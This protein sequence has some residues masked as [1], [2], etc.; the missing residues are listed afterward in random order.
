MTGPSTGPF[1]GP[2]LAD[3]AVELYALPPTD[4]TAARNARAKQVRAGGD[5]ELA[6][7]VGA[8]RR[9]TLAAWAVDLL[10]RQRPD[11]VEDLLALGARLLE[12]QAARAGDAL[13]D[14]N[15]QQHAAMAALRE[16]ARRLAH[17]AGQRLGEAVDVPLDSTLRAAMTDPAAAAA[18]RS[19]VLVTDLVSTGFGPVEVGDAVAVPDAPPLTSPRSASPPPTTPDAGERDGAQ[20]P[21]DEP[22]V[23]LRSIRSARADRPAGTARPARAARPAADRTEPG[24]P[25]DEPADARAPARRLDDERAAARRATQEREAAAREQ[26]HRRERERAEHALTAARECA[27]T[28]DRELADAEAALREAADRRSG[29]D[30]EVARLEHALAEARDARDDAARAEHEAATVREAAARAAGTAARRARAAGERLD[31]VR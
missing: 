1:T 15:R 2:S 16:E 30:A 4:F 29:R 18:V 3:V 24:E 27:T 12:A 22:E 31:A 5:R 20:P 17:D 9:P 25:A 19:G 6:A 23:E 11:Q 13:R 10:V 14:L 7:Q 26:A 28:A 21:A 8:L